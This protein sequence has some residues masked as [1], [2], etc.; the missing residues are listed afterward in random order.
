MLY[1]YSGQEDF[2]VGTPIAGRTA[3]ETEKLIGFFVNTLVLPAEVG[4]NPSFREVLRRM[5]EKTVGAYAHQ[6]VPFER[7][8]DSLQI[9]RNVN[10][11]PLFQTMFA[12]QNAGL[13]AGL[14]LGQEL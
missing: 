9:E 4:G 3:T 2:A 10:R 11:S 1:R 7:L 8:V 6:D 5:K 13:G 14:D 12:F